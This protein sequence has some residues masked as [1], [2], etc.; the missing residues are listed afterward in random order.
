MYC[1]Y[2]TFI[3]KINYLKLK[4]NF[5]KMDNCPKIWF[6]A[7]RA[8]YKVKKDC[9]SNY[10]K[11]SRPNWEKKNSFTLCPDSTKYPFD[12][13]ESG[14]D[15]TNYSLLT[16]YLLWFPIELNI[17]LNMLHCNHITITERTNLNRELIIG[18]SKQNFLPDNLCK[19]PCLFK[20]RN[21]QNKPC[22]T[23]YKNVDRP[24]RKHSSA[25]CVASRTAKPLLL[26]THPLH[27]RN[28]GEL[29]KVFFNLTNSI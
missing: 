18:T 15:R 28:N 23:R 26:L 17:H 4:K 9:I 3:N 12:Y 25:R 1:T 14:P 16:I 20:Q 2:W 27:R 11:Y 7:A 19:I 22:A 13:T 29:V 8:I 10:I 24:C 5:P 21:V 6:C